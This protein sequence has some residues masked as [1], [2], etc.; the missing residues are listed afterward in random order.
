MFSWVLNTHLNYFQGLKLSHKTQ[1]LQFTW[2][3]ISPFLCIRDALRDLV[4]FAQFKKREK[5]PWRKT[6]VPKNALCHNWF[7]SNF[8]NIINPFHAIGLFRYPLKTSMGI[9]RDQWH[10]MG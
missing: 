10:E 7:S 2:K 5:H 3:R 9:E 4:P 1:T 8:E 6:P